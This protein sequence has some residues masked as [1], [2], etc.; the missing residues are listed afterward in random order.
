MLVVHAGT[1]DG[2]AGISAGWAGISAGSAGI[3]AGWAG[4]SAGSAGICGGGGSIG[5]GGGVR[6]DGGRHCGVYRLTLLRFRSVPAFARGGRRFVGGR[7][8]G[9]DEP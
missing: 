1:T 7:G 5:G 3:S 6:L 4:I 2:W 8:G 9:G